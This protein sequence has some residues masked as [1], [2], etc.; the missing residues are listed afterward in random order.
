MNKETYIINVEMSDLVFYCENLMC[1]EQIVDH[2]P[3]CSSCLEEKKQDIS[4]ELNWSNSVEYH[5]PDYARYKKNCNKFNLDLNKDQLCKSTRWI[6]QEEFNEMKEFFKA[7][8]SNKRRKDS[9]IKYCRNPVEVGESLCLICKEEKFPEK[10]QGLDCENKAIYHNDDY[11]I[12]EECSKKKIL[13]A[14]EEK[15]TYCKWVDDESR[16]DPNFNYWHGIG[17]SNYCRNIAVIDFK[18]HYCSNI[19]PPNVNEC[20]SCCNSSSSTLD[21]PKCSSTNIQCESIICSNIATIFNR[22][23]NICNNCTTK[24]D[25]IIHRNG[26]DKILCTT[27]ETRWGCIPITGENYCFKQK[28]INGSLYCCSN[29]ILTKNEI[30][31][32]ACSTSKLPPSSSSNKEKEEEEIKRWIT[33]EQ[34]LA[35]KNK[36]EIVCP[37]SPPRGPNKAK[38]CGNIYVKVQGDYTDYRCEECEGKVGRSKELLTE[39]QKELTI[40]EILESHEHRCTYSNGKLFCG[41][42]AINKKSSTGLWEQ[43]C[44]DCITKEGNLGRDLIIAYYIKKI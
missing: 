11:S 18:T 41:K 37:Y 43:R 38:F 32:R 5:T 29:L 1:S 21:T 15:G 8:C 25:L 31:C 2:S 13:I 10:C 12:C 30:Y 27:Q 9:Q 28:L 14:K 17:E 44:L 23:Y 39:E 34:F 33:K 3:Y 40:E 22:N 6:N 20:Y 42:I 16:W 24:E 26:K 36:G 7:I 4:Q 35:K 19:L